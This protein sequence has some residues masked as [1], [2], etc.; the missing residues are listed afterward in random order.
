VWV[1]LFTVFLAGRRDG[2]DAAGMDEASWH[3]AGARFTYAPILLTAA[4]L[5]LVDRYASHPGRPAHR[6][7]L[8][9][10][11]AIVAV[12]VAA[13]FDLASER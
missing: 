13:N 2:G 7:P 9:A 8:G 4:L 11:I 1:V 10:T 5:A 3:L 6:L 12:L